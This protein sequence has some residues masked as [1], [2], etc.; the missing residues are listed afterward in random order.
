MSEITDQTMMC[1]IIQQRCSLYF[2]VTNIRITVPDK[3]GKMEADTSETE[4][5]RHLQMCNQKTKVFGPIMPPQLEQGP[6]TTSREEFTKQQCDDEEKGREGKKKRNER[7]IQQRNKKVMYRSIV[8]FLIMQVL[9]VTQHTSQILSV[10]IV[11]RDMCRLMAG[12]CYEKW[13]I[14]QFHHCANVIECTYR[15]LDSTV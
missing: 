7:R 2:F 8:L 9:T 6:E 14:G 11:I 4:G 3:E 15:N 5:H 10:I 13:V 1:H 12:I